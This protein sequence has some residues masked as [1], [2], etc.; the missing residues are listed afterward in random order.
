MMPAAV[1]P[2]SMGT[3][4]L[5]PVARDPDMGVSIPA[6]VATDPD[7]AGMRTGTAMFDDD[8]WRADLDID[9]LRERHAGDTEQC[10][11][12]NEKQFLSHGCGSSFRGK[13]GIVR[14]ETSNAAAQPMEPGRGRGVAQKM[15]SQIASVMVCEE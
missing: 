13:M 1:N 10:S 3:G 11:G 7:P 4:W 15:F 8:G 12:G 9:V 2:D 6:V 5:D 14:G